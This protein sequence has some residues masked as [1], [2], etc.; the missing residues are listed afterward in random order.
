MITKIKT[1]YVGEVRT[2]FS[3]SAGARYTFE[4][5]IEDRFKLD[6]GIRDGRN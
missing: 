2:R 5:R 4:D 3:R 6:M 1:R